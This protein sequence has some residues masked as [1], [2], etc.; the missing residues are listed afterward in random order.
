MDTAR[1]IGSRLLFRISFGILNVLSSYASAGEFQN[2]SDFSVPK[3][4]TAR[5]SKS[6]VEV[7]LFR[8]LGCIGEEHVQ[9]IMEH[10]AFL[11]AVMKD[12]TSLLAS[13][14]TAS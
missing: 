9:R 13:R 7:T 5:F 10:L 12:T 3:V 14:A 4:V 11:V 1:R 8:S 6:V 2:L